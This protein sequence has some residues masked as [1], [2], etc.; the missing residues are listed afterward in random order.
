MAIRGH[1][2]PQCDTV[3]QEE[4]GED[5]NNVVFMRRDSKGKLGLSKRKQTCRFGRLTAFGHMIK[6]AQDYD[7]V[8]RLTGL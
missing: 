7:S 3:S 6:E 8:R 5:E 1:P 4:G 2:I